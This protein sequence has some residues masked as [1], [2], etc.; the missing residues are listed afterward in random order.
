MKKAHEE[1]KHGSWMKLDENQSK[2]GS[3]SPSRV[4][5]EASMQAKP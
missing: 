1:R 3:R 2:P 4:P 5:G